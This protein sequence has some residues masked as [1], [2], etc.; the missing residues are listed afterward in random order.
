M[1]EQVTTRPL[2]KI[3]CNHVS[4]LPQ[5]EKDD[6][7]MQV[8][9]MTSSTVLIVLGA[10]GIWS[11][12]AVFARECPMRSSPTSLSKLYKIS[13]ETM[14]ASGQNRKSQPVMLRSALPSK[15]D[16]ARVYEYRPYLLE[17]AID[18]AKRKSLAERWQTAAFAYL[19]K[20]HRVAPPY[21]YSSQLP[22]RG[23][24][25]GYFFAKTHLSSFQSALAFFLATV[26][27]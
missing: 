2:R 12:S 16:M 6:A 11:P 13:E 8:P 9:R 18:D 27:R 4:A 21:R 14:S 22:T 15:A 20:W 10:P 25:S 17:R 26:M 24:R 7:A 3:T 1:I 19:K 23:N 5:L